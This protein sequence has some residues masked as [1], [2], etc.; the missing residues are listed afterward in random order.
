MGRWISYSSIVR[1]GPVGADQGTSLNSCVF[2]SQSGL[3]LCIFGYKEKTMIS[4]I[5]LCCLFSFHLSVYFSLYAEYQ[6]C[7]RVSYVQL[8][9][10]PMLGTGCHSMPIALSRKIQSIRAVIDQRFQPRPCLY[11][12]LYDILKN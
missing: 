11:I 4:H 10:F 9:V 12:L 5:Q 7:N 1:I 3:A 8:R 2:L 6:T